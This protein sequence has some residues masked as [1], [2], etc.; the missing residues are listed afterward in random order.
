MTPFELREAVAF[1]LLARPCSPAYARQLRQRVDAF[2]DW[3]GD[4]PASARL[5]N[6]FLAELAQRRQP[7]TVRGYRNAIVAVMR[8]AGWAQ[9]GPLRRVRISAKA[10]ACCTLEEVQRLVAE[11]ER[12]PGVLSNGMTRATFWPLAIDVAYSTGLRYGDLVAVLASA[13]DVAGHCLVR[14]H[15][16]EKLVRVRF[17]PEAV[18][19]IRAHG[20]A[21]AVPWPYSYNQFRVEF[22][23]LA[24][25]AG[26]R[27][28]RWKMLRATAGTHAD[29]AHP[30]LGHRLLGNT[31][32]VFDR[33]YNGFAKIHGKAIM[34]PSWRVPWYKRW[35]ARL[36]GGALPTPPEL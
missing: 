27:E 5:L 32:A 11:G 25:G 8:F 6:E 10:V 12:M 22:R 30:G 16:T 9:D 34:P 1:Y 19:G 24:A 17:T 26:L 21:E 4:R 35:L 2:A 33:H 28:V 20:L 7:E 13:I 18:A 3:L 14:Q 31:R 29:L 36:A 23:T 15:K